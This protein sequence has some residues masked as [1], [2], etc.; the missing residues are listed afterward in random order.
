MRGNWSQVPSGDHPRSRGGNIDP[1]TITAHPQGPSPLARGKRSS[2]LAGWPKCGTIPAR[3]GETRAASTSVRT[4]WD[5]P[6]SRGG[7]GEIMPT[8]VAGTG[9]SPLARGK[10]D[11][12]CFA[13][14]CSRI[15]PA[16]AG[17]T[18]RSHSTQPRFW[19]HPRSRGGNLAEMVR[20]DA[21]KGPS[22]LARG[23]RGRRRPRLFELGTIP[24]RAGE[25]G[26]AVM[27]VRMPG[28]HPRSRGG[29]GACGRRA[30][31]PAG[32][33]PLA[34]GK[35]GR[36]RKRKI[37]HGT[38][39]ARAGE[40]SHRPVLFE[41]VG[42]HPRSRG[43]NAAAWAAAVSDLGPSPLARGKPEAVLPTWLVRGTIPARAGETRR[44]LP[45]PRRRWDHP[46]SRGG[47]SRPSTSVSA[48]RGPS[49]LARGKPTSSMSLSVGAGTIPARAGET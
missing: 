31:W 45:V 10:R 4:A 36:L 18:R 3:A 39:P 48:L 8:K 30:Y 46:R 6:R 38:I 44:V 2:L 14:A 47:N 29:N 23:K 12:I 17:E 34:R 15:I 25:T 28:D 20:A 43:G 37:K 13:S 35:R 1:A 26:C 7:N 9:P 21:E 41:S 19:D 11:V 22:P 33:S 27:P 42:D 5:H 40:T 49:P 32:P 16:R 24:A